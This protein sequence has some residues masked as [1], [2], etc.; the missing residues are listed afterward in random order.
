[1]RSASSPSSPFA[2]SRLSLLERDS[3]FVPGIAV[4]DGGARLRCARCAVLHI[5]IEGPL[6]DDGVYESLKLKAI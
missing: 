2:S 6:P 1:M 5:A 4:N 3:V